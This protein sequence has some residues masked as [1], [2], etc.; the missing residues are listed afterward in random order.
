M[1]KSNKLTLTQ[2]YMRLK[3][4]IPFLFVL[5]IMLISASIMSISFKR[6]EDLNIKKHIDMADGIT[7]LMAQALDTDKIDDFIE[8][9]YSSQ[10]YMSLLKYYYMLKDSYPDVAYVY[11]YKLFK[12]DVVKATVIMDLDEAYTEDVPQESIDWIGDTF[13]ADEQFANDIDKLVTLHQPVWHI[14]H[15]REGEVGDRLLSYVKPVQDKDGHYVCCVCVAFSLD[16]MYAKG[17]DFLIEIVIIISV[18]A[19]III[20]IFNILLHRILFQPLEQMTDAISNFKYDTDSNR[21]ENVAKIES[22]K[23][24]V[25]NEIDDL[26]NALLTAMKDSVYYMTSFNKTQTELQEINEIVS[27]DSLTGVRSKSAYHDYIKHVEDDIKAGNTTFAVLMID[28]NDLKYVNDTFGHEKGNEYIKGCAQIICTACKRAPVFRVGGD[29]F[30]V[31]LQGK[32]YDMR[33]EIYQTLAD[34]FELSVSNTNTPEYAKY[35]ASIGISEYGKGVDNS[36]VDVFNRA[37]AMMYK[38]KQQFKKEHGSYR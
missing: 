5:A 9:N 26:Y 21:F 25:R 30:V 18:I 35:S 14:V 24:H 29:E 11:V 22:L 37:D 38:A 13:I 32:A 33:T 27:K 6:Y 16:G 2:K 3:T 10:D 8:E 7:T 15:A 34:A 12:D 23:I 17:L 28:L 4:R 31:I 20:I 36:Y 19:F 1:A